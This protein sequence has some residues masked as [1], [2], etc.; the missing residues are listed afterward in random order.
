M[1]PVPWKKEIGAMR[2]KVI[3]FVTAVLLT[4]CVHLGIKK[5]HRRAETG[6]AG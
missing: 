6:S 1:V 2:M 4:G 5:K 3:I